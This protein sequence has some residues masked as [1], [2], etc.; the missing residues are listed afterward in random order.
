MGKQMGVAA[1]LH[2]RYKYPTVWPPLLG[3]PGIVGVEIKVQM[4]GASGSSRGRLGHCSDPSPPGGGAG[5]ARGRQGLRLRPWAGARGAPSLPTGCGDKPQFL[6]RE[7]KP[8]EVSHLVPRWASSRHAGNALSMVK[9][10][11]FWAT[12]VSSPISPSF[13]FF[14]EYMGGGIWEAGTEL[15]AWPWT[16]V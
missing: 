12:W 9:P 1:F 8:R 6:L 3:F 7:Q 11:R 2:A 16:A 10:L 5:G 14:I 15:Q 4:Q 13:N